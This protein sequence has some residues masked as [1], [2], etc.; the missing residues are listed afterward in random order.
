[1]G[2]GDEV[3]GKAGEDQEVLTPSFSFGFAPCYDSLFSAVDSHRQHFPVK[4]H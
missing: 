1:M 3:G 4:Y 2:L